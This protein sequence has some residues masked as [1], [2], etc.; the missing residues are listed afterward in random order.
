MA[1]NCEPSLHIYHLYSYHYCSSDSH[2]INLRDVV[3]IIYRLD[4][5]YNALS[6]II[7]S[8]IG[9]SPNITT[10]RLMS[11]N[12]IGVVP[13]ALIS[14][15]SLSELLLSD[16]LLSGFES[17]VDE[18]SITSCDI[19]ANF[20]ACP[21]PS[22]VNSSCSGICGQVIL[23]PTMNITREVQR[24]VSSGSPT[25][26]LLFTPGYYGSTV[27]A[28][29]NAVDKQDVTFSVY[30]EGVVIMDGKSQIL[31]NGGHSITLAGLQ[32]INN[33]GN[34]IVSITK[35]SSVYL[36]N[37]IFTLNDRSDILI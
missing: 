13:A 3:L 26:Q 34:N 21:I 29:F 20:L 1:L 8:S 33:T 10:V 16:N 9:N 5:S 7:P 18:P 28:V 22:W 4:V 32:F 15:P 23:Y 14:N 31:F 11:N 12:L 37:S 6:G 24:A 19:S 17:V 25:A 36:Y 27:N 2:Q 30:G 35:T